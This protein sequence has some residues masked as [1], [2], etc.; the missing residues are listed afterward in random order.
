MKGNRKRG[1]PQR[2]WIDAVMELLEIQERFRWEW[3]T[4]MK[5]RERL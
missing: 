5:I 4:G 3:F 2:R 1:R